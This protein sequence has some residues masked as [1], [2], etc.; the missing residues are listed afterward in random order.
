MRTPDIHDK[1]RVQVALTPRGEQLA[2][3]ENRRA[4]EFHTRL[5]SQLKPG[6]AEQ[7][8]D[9]LVRLADTVDETCFNES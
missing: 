7:L 8:L 1:R 2:E 6:E 9:M 4:I 5:L 3:A